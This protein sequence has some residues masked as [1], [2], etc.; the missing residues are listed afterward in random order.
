MLLMS[1]RTSSGG[2]CVVDGENVPVRHGRAVV[3]G[4][5]HTMRLA[6]PNSVTARLYGL[7]PNHNVRVWC[8]CMDARQRQHIDPARYG[9]ADLTT[10]L[11]TD[12][13]WDWLGIADTRIPGSAL[14][15]FRAHLKE[16]AERAAQG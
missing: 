4:R 12:L 14:S 2:R 1:L 3:A 13:E 6:K 7:N 5:V 15:L 9:Y 11:Q 10:T 8:E 16:V